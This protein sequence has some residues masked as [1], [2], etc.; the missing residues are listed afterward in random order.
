EAI[1]RYKARLKKEK[2]AREE[3]ERRREEREKLEKDKEVKAKELINQKKAVWL[4]PIGVDSATSEFVER[5]YTNLKPNE[6]S[7]PKSDGKQRYRITVLVPHAEGTYTLKINPV[8]DNSE[9][10]GNY[11]FYGNFG[12]KIGI[13]QSSGPDLGV[14]VKDIDLWLT[15]NTTYTITEASIFNGEKFQLSDTTL[16]FHTSSIINQPKAPEKKEDNKQ[17][18]ENAGGSQQDGNNGGSTSGGADKQDLTF[19]ENQFYFDIGGR[20]DNKLQLILQV[21]SKYIKKQDGG[22]F[23]LTLEADEVDEDHSIDEISKIDDEGQQTELKKEV[24]L[25]DETN[26]VSGRYTAHFTMNFKDTPKWGKLHFKLKKLSY[27]VEQSSATEIPLTSL[28][29]S[30]VEEQVEIAKS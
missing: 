23:F 21:E 13:P 7:L 11:K 1:D 2:Q 19:P 24:V 30:S 29:L 15:P 5:D 6:G 4:F 28:D 18:D 9:S 26:A 16:I 17:K 27:G 12:D 8:V 22:K 3:E 14:T 25:S 10:D 20:K